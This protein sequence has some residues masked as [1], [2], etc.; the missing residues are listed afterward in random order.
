MGRSPPSP[1][2]P[3]Y[4]SDNITYIE[5][6]IHTYIIIS[7]KGVA[8]RP[9]NNIIAVT[10]VSGVHTERKEAAAYIAEGIGERSTFP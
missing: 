8:R 6:I 4:A 9:Y 2:P 3:V 1:P 7:I 5:L 10:A